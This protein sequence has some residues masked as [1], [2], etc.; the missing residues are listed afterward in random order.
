M[1]NELIVLRKPNKTNELLLVRKPKK[2]N[3]LF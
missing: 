1:K 3:E 2:K